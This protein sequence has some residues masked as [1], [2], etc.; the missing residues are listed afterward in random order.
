MI[1]SLTDVP[2]SRG[3]IRTVFPWRFLLAILVGL[4]VGAAPL[5]HASD[6][7]T[8]SDTSTISDADYG[9]PNLS[10]IW[11]NNHQHRWDALIPKNDGGT[12]A[13]DHYIMREVSGSQIFTSVELED[14]N[15]ARPDAFWD[16]ATKTLYVLGS[17]STT[18]KLWKVNYDIATDSYTV[19]PNVNGVTVSGIVH[20]SPNRPAALYVSPNGYVWVGVLNAYALEVQRSVDGGA[21]WLPSPINL[22][23]TALSGVVSWS[24]FTDQGISYVGLF[25]GENATASVNTLFYYWYIGQDSDPSV[26]TNWID[27][28]PNIPDLPGTATSDDHVATAADSSGNLYFVVKTQGGGPSDPL[29]NLYKRT[30]AGVWSQYPVTETREDPEQS[31]PSLVVDDGKSELYVFMSDTNYGNGNHK[32][33]SLTSLSDLAGAP[34]VSI[35]SS[36]NHLF[37]NIITPRHRI[38]LESGL[39]V[40][41]HDLVDQ[42]VWWARVLAPCGTEGGPPCSEECGTYG[43]PPCPED[44]KECRILSGNVRFNNS[45]I[46]WRLENEGDIPATIRLISLGWSNRLGQLREVRLGPKIFGGLIS[47][48]SADITSFEGRD[49]KRRIDPGKIKEL[50]F[51]LGRK[52]RNRNEVYHIR[53][54]FEEGCEVELDR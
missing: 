52:L 20:E 54:E 24:H 21:S 45:E 42:T 15:T 11:Y 10:R 22:D 29:I 37:G 5:A 34:L 41:A 33:V 6:V 1:P 18:T 2:T 35:F 48:S 8:G 39:V 19:D 50:T 47:P 49:Q 14:R 44:V 28:S 9:K 7:V 12:S 36:E 46:R 31:R 16:E 4:A 23:V 38:T 17:H 3:S 40:L 51:K 32:K 30:P 26:P 25:A 43:N 13:S 53:V 27:D